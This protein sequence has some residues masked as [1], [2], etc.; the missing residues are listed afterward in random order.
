MTAPSITIDELF[1]DYPLPQFI[2]EFLHRLPFALPHAAKSLCRWGMWETIAHIVQDGSNADVLLV[3]ANEQYAGELPSDVRGFLALS[4]EGYTTLIR[5][6]E[7]HHEGLAHLAGQFAHTF[8]GPVDAHLY[9]TP[10]GQY[11]FSWHYDAEDVFILQLSGEKEYSLRKNTVNPWPLAES[12]PSDM[13]Y[14][15]ELMPL[16]RVKLQ[17][18]DMLYIP[19]G[20]WHRGT[21]KETADT[22]F[23]L[24]I[25]IMSPAAIGVLGLLRPHLLESLL[26][27]QRLPIVTSVE[28]SMSAYQELLDMLAADLNKVITSA[29]FREQLIQSRSSSSPAVPK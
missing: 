18:G 7:R 27:R 8:Q 29:E 25:G 23:S 17:A 24:A 11:G 15:R 10:P 28:D 20:Y 13:H 6:A 5:H 21:A 9:A 12:L 2:S 22:A 14:E 19:C 4:H 26:W 1:A 16:T 3:R